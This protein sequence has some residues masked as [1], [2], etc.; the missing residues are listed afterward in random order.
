MIQPI[1][2]SR[3]GVGEFVFYSVKKFLKE[4]KRKEK[5]GKEKKRKRTF[6]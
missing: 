1:F 5:K 3:Q 2:F 6:F 4:K